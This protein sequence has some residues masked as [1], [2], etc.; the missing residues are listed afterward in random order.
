MCKPLLIIFAF[1]A[2]LSCHSTATKTWKNDKIDKVTRAQIQM[3]NGRLMGALLK[4]D[5]AGVTALFSPVLLQKAEGLDSFL[6]EAFNAVKSTG[7]TVLDEY[8]VH[9]AGL[10]ASV[11]LPANDYTLQFQA[12]NPDSYVALLLTN[13]VN[14]EVLLTIIYGKYENEWKINVCRLGQYALLKKNSYDYYLQAR[15]YYEDGHLADAINNVDAALFCAK[16][17]EQFISFSHSQEM[18]SFSKRIKA[19][20]ERKFTFPI[21]LDMVK[22]NPKIL[23]VTA[24]LSDEGFFPVVVYQSDISLKDTVML[25]K[26]NE[27]M[28]KEIGHLFEGI[29]KNNK[30]IIYRAVN[31]YTVGERP[32]NMYVFID[33]DPG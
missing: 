3:L 10:G 13:N 17:A 30:I 4:K 21:P 33:R 1:A 20:A 2:L 24:H 9:S 15:K 29:D 23:Q 27:L 31:E 22:T 28:R 6:R 26:E 12:V 18:E 32:A 16:P 25:K 5:P 8:Y 11:V 14:V 19:E 7:Y